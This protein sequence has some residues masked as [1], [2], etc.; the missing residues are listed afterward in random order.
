MLE[1]PVLEARLTDPCPCGSGRKYK[2]CC[3]TRKRREFAAALADI[4]ESPGA[5][6]AFIFSRFQSL[7]EDTLERLLE[8]TTEWVGTEAVEETIEDAPDIF[9]VY[10]IEACLVDIPIENGKTGVE[11]YLADPASRKL[12]P[13]TREYLEAYARS[14]YSLYEVQDVVRGKTVILKDLLRRR[15][16]T[17][18][19]HSTSMTLYR[20][21]VCFARVVEM[22]SICLLPNILLPFDRAFLDPLLEELPEIKRDNRGKR[23]G[24]LQ[25]FK[26]EWP[27]ALALWISL[28]QRLSDPTV[29][30]NTEGDP[31][32][33]IELAFTIPAGKLG[34]LTRRLD[35]APEL[36]PDGA[37]HW[38]FVTPGEGAFEEGVLR[39]SLLLDGDTLQVRVNSERREAEVRE[40]LD[41]L[42]GNCLGEES[43]TAIEVT[44][45]LLEQRRREDPEPEAE[46]PP[47]PPEIAEQAVHHVLERHYRDWVDH[48]LPA[49]DGMTPRQAAADPGMKRRL[50][51]LLKDLE[52]HQAR[53]EGHMATYDVSW[54]WSELGLK[55]P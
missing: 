55:R 23:L 29:L 25:F 3:W 53:T 30:T 52:L 6:A 24:W 21:Q 22:E 16:L 10:A 47:V 9:N 33:L 2:R 15:T 41:R 14:A 50:V 28:N 8:E 42:A 34:E 5:V 46:E 32:V 20:F 49:L 45:E 43:R 17:V 54:L 1:R 31:L 38:A 13:T 12:R 35:S 48:P 39:A 40:L 44:P 27:L 26:R 4:H 7:A 19:D 51:S 37:G 18:L 36:Q 11:L